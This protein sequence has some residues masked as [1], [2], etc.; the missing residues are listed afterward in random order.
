MIYRTLSKTAGFALSAA[1]PFAGVEL[2]ERLA[3]GM[4]PSV[5]G[6]IWVHGASVGELNSARLIVEALAS[7]RQVLVT[8]NTVTGRDVVR[9]WGLEARLAPLDVPQA[10]RRFLDAVQPIL[11]LTIENEIWPN[12]AAAL[13][14]R[15]I[16]QAVIGARM[17]ARSAR[18]WARA[19]RLIGPLLGGIDLLSAQ[20]EDTEARLVA[21]GLP[22]EALTVRTNLK[23]IGPASVAVPPDTQ[24]RWSTWLA[25]ST[26]PGEEEIVLDAHVALRKR[27]PEAR[28]ILAPR[29]PKRSD[30]VAAL[31][32]ARG[33]PEARLG[34][35]SVEDVEPAPVLLIDRL[36]A[37]DGAYAAA[38]ICL[39]G[40]SLVDHGGHT[41]WEPAAYRCALLHGPHVANA[42]ASY[43]A[44]DGAGASRIV[45]S[46]SLPQLLDALLADPAQAR[47]MGQAARDALDA[48]VP[49]PAELVDRL[50]ALI[51][52]HKGSRDLI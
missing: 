37:M 35:Q 45:D 6:P 1:S 13:R 24:D 38:G 40:G 11:A 9:S 12:R 20:D 47:A 22:P 2:R 23:L 27:H 31:I 42:S 18:N 17:S 3:L 28:L 30:E 32:K 51:S 39:T 41:P 48:A 21:L 33:F 8:T 16:P 25:A 4:A 52:L 36:G 19:P 5:G 7:R 44:L 50:I 34:K 14:L 26:H 43:A 10:L 49:D 15:D 29:H 46:A